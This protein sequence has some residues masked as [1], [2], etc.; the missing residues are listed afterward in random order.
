VKNLHEKHK[1]D[2]PVVPVIR[3]RVLSTEHKVFETKPQMKQ[4][5]CNFDEKYKQKN[6]EL[7]DYEFPE[8]FP[9]TSRAIFVFQDQPQTKSEIMLF[10]LH[11]NE[12]SD[13][14]KD[15]NDR[16]LYISYLDSVHY[17]EPKGLRTIT[18]YE[19]ILSYMDFMRRSGFKHASIW[20][21]PP[22]KNDDY[23]FYVH[24][25]EQKIPDSDNLLVWY[26]KLFSHGIR[27]RIIS[28][29][30]DISRRAQRDEP[31]D[32]EG[33]SLKL[34]P[35]P[36]LDGDFWPKKIEEELLEVGE[37]L[38]RNNNFSLRVLVQE[39]NTKIRECMEEEQNVKVFFSVELAD[40][41]AFEETALFDP[42]GILDIDLSCDIFAGREPFLT[43]CRQE[44]MQFGTERTA[45]HSTQFIVK[46]VL[47]DQKQ[48][49]FRF[50]NEV[51]HAL[52]CNTEECNLDSCR[53]YKR[54]MKIKNPTDIM[55]STMKD[56]FGTNYSRSKT[57]REAML[58]LAKDALTHH[59]SLCQETHDKFC[60]SVKREYYM[61]RIK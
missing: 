20:S 47:N 21:C 41:D 45:T 23:I 4:L 34:L 25:K 29:F 26:E 28:D 15:P 16:R 24:P 5:F 40:C 60:T 58:V 43:L 7:R 36:Y 12:Y 55:I 13:L 1:K 39:V 37:R 14:A 54:I 61:H 30:C 3:I 11:V 59:V 17:F 35:Y 53:R 48:S 38:M 51:L 19:I 10:G 44:F 2:F 18:Y 46:R 31:L 8:E 56:I 6:T 9:Y 52:K 22:A 57:I 50:F 49:S 42:I 32:L 33:T 27:R